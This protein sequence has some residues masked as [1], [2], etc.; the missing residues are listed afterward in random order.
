MAVLVNEIDGWRWSRNEMLQRKMG[1]VTRL[2]ATKV[3]NQHRPAR[4]SE[5]AY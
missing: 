1:E 4:V 3:V 2:M 5:G